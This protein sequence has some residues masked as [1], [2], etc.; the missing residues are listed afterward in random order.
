MDGC[1]ADGR[2]AGRFARATDFG[3]MLHRLDITVT[4]EPARRIREAEE[5][6]R[7]LHFTFRQGE[8]GFT[9]DPL[10]RNL[11]PMIAERLDLWRLSNFT[12]QRMSQRRGYLP[13]PGGR[14]PE[15]EGR[16]PDRDRRGSR[17]HPGQRPG[18]PDN[19]LPAAGGMLAQAFADI[20]HAL[21][22]R[23]PKQRPLSNRMI[24]YVRPT[25][26]IAKGPGAG[27]PPAGT[28][29]RGPGH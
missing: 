17:P 27:G 3:H 4:S 6:L 23:P 22:R 9:E 11:H 10:Y 29:G 5:H 28:D 20:R 19:R 1:R 24:L 2:R 13:V 26:D 18:G 16:A 12:L 15:P 25:W 14:P 21:G 7:T 8:A